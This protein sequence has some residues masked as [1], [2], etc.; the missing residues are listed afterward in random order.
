MFTKRSI[1]RLAGACL[2]SGLMAF[3]A[4]GLT[5]GRGVGPMTILLVLMYGFLTILSAVAVYMVFNSRERFLAIIGAFG[6]GGHGLFVVLVSA[7][8][9]A[10]LEF[11]REF[12]TTGEPGTDS[13]TAAARSLALTMGSIRAFA[14]LFLGFG[15][16]SLG[17]LIAWSGAFARWL[18]WLGVFAGVLGFLGALMVIFNV[19]LSPF[20]FM[21]GVFLMFVFI[22]ALGI[23]LLVRRTR[24]KAV[25][26]GGQE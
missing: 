13:V 10:Q 26:V 21:T 20:I 16:A 8:L 3:L 12:T 6:L 4:H 7:L 19:A 23:R 17:G 24:E 5:L 22:L 25:K 1:E 9:V 15:L 14:F 11:A 18:G 2:I